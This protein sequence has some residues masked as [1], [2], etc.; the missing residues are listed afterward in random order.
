MDSSDRRDIAVR[1][2]GRPESPLGARLPVGAR[3]SALRVAGWVAALC[4]AFAMGAVLAWSIGGTTV[5]AQ[6]ESLCVPSLMKVAAPEEI[7]LGETVR[8]TLTLEIGCPDEEQPIDVVLVVDES[9]SMSDD[10]KIDIARLAGLEFLNAMD[11]DV[12]RV[13]MVSFTNGTAALR[14]G[15][16]NDRTRIERALGALRPLGL[17]NISYAITLAHNELEAN[18][19]DGVTQAIVVL[20]DGRQ[21]QADAEPILTAADR[22]KAD[23]IL[24]ATFCAGVDCDADLSQA[25]SSSD[26]HF[27]VPDPSELPGL[28]R[29]LA[30]TLQ[31]NGIATLT[32]RDE[33]PSNM[34]YI[35]GSAEPAPSEEGPGYLVWTF[36]GLPPES[37]ISYLLEP[38]QPGVHPTNIVATVEFTDLHG[39]PGGATFP[40]PRVRVVGPDC[41]LQPVEIYFLIDDSNCLF[42]HMLNG[43][44]S[45]TAIRMG[46]EAVVDQMD[47]ATDKAMVIGFGD[48]AIPL[49]TLTSDK[50]LI[51]DAVMRLTMRDGTARL[52]LAFDEVAKELEGPRHDP[53][54]RIIT[55]TITDGPMMQIPELAEL[56]G[57]ALRNRYGAHHYA[58]AI[59]FVSQHSVLRAVCD[60]GGY[61]EIPFGGDVITP[62]SE[63]GGIGIA[64]RDGCPPT[65]ASPTP[66]SVPPGGTPTASPTPRHGEWL[67]Y[68]PALKR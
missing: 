29:T 50:Q 45:L 28:Y 3:L 5:S 26:L 27:D 6:A 35:V 18:G 1:L 65:G 44:D 54:A 8:V 10:G 59:G 67:T 38:L 41:V 22:A 7:Q 64:L 30:G 49:Q 47:L 61:R 32:I 52:D 53:A 68:L 20:T 33:I 4:A 9:S 14:S 62:M 57:I 25:A 23:G 39:H 55:L 21:T 48:R 42:G 19:R 66:S 17:T 2:G 46:V 34:R 13:G 11:L 60:P 63:L 36:A 56:K 43:V 58:V 37:G 15:L 24:I 40:V 16:T 12:S 31:A 51:L